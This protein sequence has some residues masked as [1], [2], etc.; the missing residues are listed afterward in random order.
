[1]GLFTGSPIEIGTELDNAG[2]SSMRNTQRAGVNNRYESQA[3][4][5]QMAQQGADTRL[6]FTQGASNIIGN[7]EARGNPYVQQGMATDRSG[8][9]AAAAGIGYQQQ[10]YNDVGNWLA[11]GPGPSVAQQ[12][13]RQQNDM[14]QANASSLAQSGRGAGGS[15]SAM[16]QALF[17]NAASGQQMNQQAAVAG[18]QE[19]QAWRQQQLQATGMRSDMGANISGQGMQARGI[20]LQQ[21]QMGQNIIGQGA[22]LGA[23]MYQAG[24][25][26]QLQWNQMGNQAYQSEEQLRGQMMS[27]TQATAAQLAMANQ[28]DQEAT[29]AG[30]LGFFGGLLGGA[31]A[32][33]GK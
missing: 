21:G 30:T 3:Y 28:K 24:A 22:A 6:Q 29:D 23:N 27:N 16:R 2:I 13:L 9:A 33:A 8:A 11:R 32:A 7:A 17:A 1:M 18:A 20:G 14:N 19:Q 25:D 10:A 4:R 12:Q 26:N 5:D 15:A 31:G